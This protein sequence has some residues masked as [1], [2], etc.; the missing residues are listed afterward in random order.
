MKR[1]ILSILFTL[2]LVLSFS[3][4]PAV[5]AMA[6]DEAQTLNVAK[7]TTPATALT[8]AERPT[9]LLDGAIYHMWYV[10]SNVVYHTV[11]TDPAS[12]TTGTAVT[13]LVTGYQDC[14]FVM[15]EGDTYYMLNYGDATSKVFSIF[16]SSNGTDWTAK[17]KIYDGTGLSDWEKID[18]PKL[19]EESDDTYKMYFQVKS[20]NGSNPYYIYLA[21][22]NQ[23]SLAVIADSNDDND[24][25]LVGTTPV[26]SP[27]TTA[28]EWDGF[29]VMQPMVVKD[30]SNYYM[31]YLG[32]K[33]TDMTGKIGFAFSSN[34]LDWTKGH[35]NP[36]LAGNVW[37][38]S[39]LKA[40]GIYHIWYMEGSGIEHISANAPI[41]FS[42]IQ[43]AVNAALSGNTIIVAAGTYEE[44]VTVGKVLTLTGN[45]AE[46]SAATGNAV[47]VSSENVTIEGF[48]IDC[49]GVADFGVQVGSV[50][51]VA[52]QN[53]VIQNYYKAGI[54]VVGSSVS[55]AGNEIVGSLSD[56]YSAD[57]IYT[58]GGATVIVADNI[59]RG[60]QYA[61]NAYNPA[62]SDWS[63]AAGLSVHQSDIVTATG[64][65]IYDNDFGI[66]AK[67]SES[68]GANPIVVANFNNI[69]DNSQ[70]FF[71]EVRAGGA[72]AS[73][74]DATN[75]W[76]GNASGPADAVKFAAS[77]YEASGNAVSAN[78]DYEPWLLAAA[79]SG[80]TPTTYTKT[81]ALKDGW[82][83]VSTDKEVTTDT[84]WTATVA[85][86]Y[87]AGAYTQ[88]T[89]ATQLTSVDAYYLKTSGGGGVGINYSTSSPGVV[90]KSLGAGWNTISC[91]GQTDAHTLLQQLRYVQTSEVGPNLM[92]LVGQGTYNQFT[93]SSYTTLATLDGWAAIEPGGVSSITLNAFDGYWVYMNA[94]KS[95]G[96]IPD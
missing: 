74:Y 6:V 31:W 75:N 82:T 43:A 30:G 78:V 91:A 5:P 4:I 27:S 67:G 88:V 7:W 85:Y 62:I 68:G 79:V 10:L 26:L 28:E 37:K 16:T 46:I 77:G 38:P 50:T 80:V 32:Y 94:A 19:L 92:S 33:T 41:Q 45:A 55:I 60:N 47:T 76:W 14:P 58:E 40:D 70:G 48:V 21:T 18:N 17:G 13:G 66:H 12:F 15:K 54:H 95:F 9:V 39:V 25:T 42:A 86:K 52:I 69:Y 73:P 81:L 24:F 3:L 64:N 22:T 11:S 71:Y 2:V 56:S 87:T 29:R 53:N 23:T 90:T 61:G 96:V 63:T 65:T 84:D 44:N 72:P 49:Q 1:K 36:I 35:G 83:L 89:L 8:G 20:S 34:G 57:S 93:D 51:G 59:L